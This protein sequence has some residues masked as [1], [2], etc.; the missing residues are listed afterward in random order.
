MHAHSTSGRRRFSGGSLERR[1]SEQ[2]GDVPGVLESSPFERS[3]T[4]KPRVYIETSVLSYLTSWPSRDLVKAAHQEVTMEW[5][6]GRER[7]DLFVSEAVLV[8][9][10]RG[11]PEAAR[12]RLVATTGLPALT[13]TAEAQALAGALLKAAAMPAKAAMDAA[14]VAIATVHGM[15]FLLT[16]NCT[17]IANA[18]MRESIEEVCRQHGFR[19]PVICTPEELT[20]QEDT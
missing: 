8:E 11:D 2:A 20:L 13:A 6:A 1:A 9:I 10:S 16:W 17:H 7:F 14:H 15:N 5:W 12:I 4:V 3:C 19:P 18:A